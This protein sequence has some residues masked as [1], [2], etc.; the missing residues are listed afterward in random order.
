MGGR[1]RD[2]PRHET[3]QRFLAGATLAFGLF[4]FA[5]W[6]WEHSRAEARAVRALARAEAACAA[7]VREAV[8]LARDGYILPTPVDAPEAPVKLS[9]AG[10]RTRRDVTPRAPAPHPTGGGEIIPEYGYHQVTIPDVPIYGTPGDSVPRGATGPADSC[11][12]DVR[13]GMVRAEVECDGVSVP[14]VVTGGWA[15]PATNDVLITDKLVSNWSAELRAGITSGARWSAGATWYG[16]SRVGAW[17]QA[18]PGRG[19]GGVALRL[20]R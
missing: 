3:K 10:P 2:L 11:H 1:A 14:C 19:S 8:G 18:E 4:G 9:P 20:G 12:V 15:A 16:R 7:A 13:S 17:A 5:G 6:A